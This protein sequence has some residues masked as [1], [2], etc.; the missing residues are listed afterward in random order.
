ML[1]FHF[2]FP[3]D[4]VSQASNKNLHHWA[5]GH[6]YFGPRKNQIFEVWWAAQSRP[7]KKTREHSV[8]T[9]ILLI[10]QLR[11]KHHSAQ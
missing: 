4:P 11:R 8:Y 2:L 9:L 5:E 3:E 10:R 6:L 7:E 1:N